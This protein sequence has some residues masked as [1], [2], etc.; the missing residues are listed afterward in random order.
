MSDVTRIISQMIPSREPL[1]RKTG[2]GGRI[3]PVDSGP[4]M[5]PSFNVLDDP[6]IVALLQI[7]NP[8][9]VKHVREEVLRHFEEMLTGINK[10][11]TSQIRYTGIQFSSDVR[12]GRIVAVVRDQNSGE[13]LKVMPA[14]SILEV[15]ARLQKASGVLLNVKA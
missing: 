9:S 14:R 2:I 3:V 12:S 15:A 5:A 1:P 7:D 11:I 4:L 6:R 8:I 10:Y 13:V